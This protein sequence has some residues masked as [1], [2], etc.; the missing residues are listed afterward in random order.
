MVV[1]GC[2]W[3]A[4]ELASRYSYIDLNDGKFNN[5][6]RMDDW[7]TGVNWYLNPYTKFQANYVK[8]FVNNPTFG[9]SYA[10]MFGLRAQVDF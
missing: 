2:G 5:G 1:S 3:G 8:S 9:H 4:W 6:G 7:T 10:N